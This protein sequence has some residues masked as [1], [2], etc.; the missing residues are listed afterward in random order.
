MPFVR[1]FYDTVCRC[2]LCVLRGPGIG[3][4]SKRLQAGRW[5]ASGPEP[6]D[7]SGL[8]KSLL[9]VYTWRTLFRSRWSLASKQTEILRQWLLRGR[10]AILLWVV[11]FRSGVCFDTR[12][13]WRVLRLGLLFF[14]SVSLFAL[15]NCPYGLGN[16][17]SG[18]VIAFFNLVMTFR[19]A[20]QS[21]NQASIDFLC[22]PCKTQRCGQP[23]DRFVWNLGDLFFTRIRNRVV[24]FFVFVQAV[25]DDV[26]SH[27]ISVQ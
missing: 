11:A 26:D 19:K 24:H 8:D 18:F 25:R 7:S 3:A 14:F 22:C 5:V 4:C 15:F 21:F 23:L 6:L 1:R 27:Q 9:C 13:D 20:R 12:F 17:L 2:R 10:V 16:L